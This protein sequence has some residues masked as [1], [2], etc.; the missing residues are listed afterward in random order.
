MSNPRQSD[1]GMEAFTFRDGLR[2]GLPLVIPVGIV[3]VSFGVLARSLDWGVVAPIVMSI[4]VFSGSAQF[5]SVGV[6]AAGG[7][8]G[9]AI[10][11]ATLSNLRF[12]PLGLISA[13]ATR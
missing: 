10:I 7:G 13:P 6:L 2:A 5:A 4:I 1:G 9:P 11:A 3:G 8:P 12:L